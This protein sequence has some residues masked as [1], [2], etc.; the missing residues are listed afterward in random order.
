[1]G[2]ESLADR[3][4]FSCYCFMFD[5]FFGRI[6]SSHILLLINFT[7]PMVSLRSSNLLRF[8]FH[9]TDYGYF[10]PITNMVR[11]F[12]D[13]GYLFDFSMSR[14]QFKRIIETLFILSEYNIYLCFQFV[15]R[16]CRFIF[17]IILNITLS[18]EFLL[19]DWINK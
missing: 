5:L 9:R 6:D 7:V 11:F 16:K 4:Q 13:V 12:N 19:I 18:E 15:L 10:E 14:F 17:K 3:R 8:N 1:M 2:L